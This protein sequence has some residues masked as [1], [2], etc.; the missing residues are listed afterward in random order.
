LLSALA[1]PDGA[2]VVATLQPGANATAV[3]QAAFAAWASE[4]VV[5]IVG[6]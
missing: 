2:R 6:P 4:G 3:E 1:A 5:P